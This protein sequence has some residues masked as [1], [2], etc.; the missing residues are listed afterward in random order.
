MDRINY[1]T[2]SC[3]LSIPTEIF[4]AL[5]AQTI[6]NAESFGGVLSYTDI[7]IIVQKI[8]VLQK[9][10]KRV[11]L[12]QFASNPVIIVSWAEFLQTVCGH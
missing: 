5:F 4:F 7:K 8:K 6:Q 1:T 12:L 11:S 3:N 10:E 2:I 9:E